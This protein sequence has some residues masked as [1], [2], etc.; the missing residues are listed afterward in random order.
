MS[1]EG[2]NLLKGREGFSEKPNDDGYGNMTQGFGNKGSLNGSP[3]DAFTVKVAEADQAVNKNVKVPLTQAPHDALS[4]LAYNIGSSGFEHSPILLGLSNTG[5]FD[6]AADQI[7]Q[8]S[9]AFNRHTNKM[10][11]SRGLADRRKN[12]RLQFLGKLPE[13]TGSGH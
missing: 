12:E 1:D 11:F 8:F 5:K 4:S 2:R 9:H 3:D 7:L 10:E 13:Q 6:E